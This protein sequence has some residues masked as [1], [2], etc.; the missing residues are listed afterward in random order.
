LLS[1]IFIL[2]FSSCYSTKW[3][4]EFH[5]C[6]FNMSV[7]CFTQSPAFAAIQHFWFTDNIMK[8]Q[9]EQVV[10]LMCV[11][12]LLLSLFH[13]LYYNL[14][15]ILQ[16]FIAVSYFMCSRFK[17]LIYFPFNYYLNSPYITRSS[18]EGSYFGQSCWYFNVIQFGQIN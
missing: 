11:S 8:P 3:S 12:E 17:F 7:L 13:F 1:N 15:Q 5:L 2:D 9:Q 6:R 4:Q 18:S 14:L 10:P 16:S